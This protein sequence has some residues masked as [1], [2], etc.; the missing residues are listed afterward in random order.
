[1]LCS[2]NKGADQLWGINTVDL[3]LCFHICKKQVFSGHSSYQVRN[4][5]DYF[6]HDEAHIFKPFPVS[7]DF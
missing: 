7:I 1:M 4:L 5:Q 2:E 3:H 6:S